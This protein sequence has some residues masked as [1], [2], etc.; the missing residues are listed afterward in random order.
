VVGSP[1][2]ETTIARNSDRVAYLVLSDLFIRFLKFNSNNFNG[3]NPILMGRNKV[4]KD[5]IFEGLLY[6][7]LLF[8]HWLAEA[9]QASLIK[10][11]YCVT[12]QQG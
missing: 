9:Q 6:R 8:F 2:M 12:L 11:D 3:L 4:L 5:I 10:E 7:G 1:L